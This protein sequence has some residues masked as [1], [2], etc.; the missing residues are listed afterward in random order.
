MK[1]R[2]DRWWINEW[3]RENCFRDDVG[4]SEMID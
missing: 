3:M 2:G 1:I 4:G